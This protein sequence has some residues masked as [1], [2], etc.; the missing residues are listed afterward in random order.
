MSQKLSLARMYVASD[1]GA[2]LVVALSVCALTWVLYV[3]AMFSSLSTFIDNQR[4]PGFELV[5]GAN[6]DPLRL[7]IHSMYNILPLRDGVA[8]S[9]ILQVKESRGVKY[10]VPFLSGESLQHVGLLGTSQ[11]VFLAWLQEEHGI[12]IPT[13]AGMCIAGSATGLPVGSLHT[14]IHHHDEIESDDSQSDHAHDHD[15]DHAHDHSQCSHD[16]QVR[17][18]AVL[19]PTGTWLDYRVFCEAELL[20]QQHYD[21]WVHMFEGSGVTPPVM[22]DEFRMYSWVGIGL[23]NPVLAD[24]VRQAFSVDGMHMVST[25]KELKEVEAAVQKVAFWAAYTD[26]VVFCAAIVCTLLLL[27]LLRKA[28][29]LR[30]LSLVLRDLSRTASTQVLSVTLL[31]QVGLGSLLFAGS[32]FAVTLLTNVTENQVFA[33]WLNVDSLDVWLNAV[34]VF[35]TVS[36]VGTVYMYLRIRNKSFDEYL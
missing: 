17:I 22:S 25:T 1:K 5:A 35:V 19:P 3:A 31:M 18:T 24:R 36:L 21:E 12:E 29:I 10:A 34:T 28:L 15:H 30:V 7:S 4:N 2:T 26:V 32:L 16:Q 6:G 23:K 14:V 9:D 27:I 13:T 33:I 20:W 11:P 8:A